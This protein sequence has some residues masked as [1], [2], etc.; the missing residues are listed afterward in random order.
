[1]N[2]SSTQTQVILVDKNDKIIGYKE[3]V[4]AHKYPLP[5][6]RAI[7]VVVFDKRG[8]KI[9]LQKR[10]AGKPTWPLFW[11]NTCCT[12]PLKGELY[13]KAAERR[14]REEMGFSAPLTKKFKFLYKAKYSSIWGEH[15]LDAVFVG[16][17][18]GKISPDPKEVADYK[19]MKIE[20]LLRDV[21]ENPDI[22]SPWFKIIL[23]KLHLNRTRRTL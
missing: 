4:L 22:Y 6:H 17:Y 21:R 7:S 3:K 9:L 19:W 10:A 15:E 1:M 2:T 11:S 5:L 14:L 20:D 8:R 12:H 23:K 13:K 18:E 16:N